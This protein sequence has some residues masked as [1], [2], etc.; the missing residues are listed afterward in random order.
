MTVRS[1]DDDA[2]RMRH[3]AL[4]RI[5]PFWD[6]QA[7]ILVAIALDTVLP[8]A[9]LPAYWWL[10]TVVGAAGL[11]A[12]MW[13]TPWRSDTP[14]PASDRRRRLFL[15]VM[16]VVVVLHLGAL[17]GLVADILGSRNLSGGEL[18]RGA[19]QLW[20]ATVLIFAVLFWDLD[21]GGPV[22]RSADGP[23]PRPPGPGF[24][25]RWPDF[26]FPQM[27]DDAP[28]PPRWMP[29]FVDYL[30]LAATNSTAFSPT[31]T[32][33]LSRPAKLLMLVQSTTSFVLVALVAARAVNV[34]R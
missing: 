16:A 24:A 33:P 21:R 25:G 29:G 18:L 5:E 11:A 9:L 32:M 1:A 14:P 19:A 6:A 22:A 27:A 20:L 13:I 28:A 34:L 10:L 2:P 23:V 17:V 3:E 8:G 30:Y 26:L 31:D 15:G 7:A 4:H 12:L